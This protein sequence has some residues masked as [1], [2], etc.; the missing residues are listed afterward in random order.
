MSARPEPRGKVRRGRWLVTRLGAGLDVCRAQDGPDSQGIAFQT[1]FA[2]S[3][4][5]SR[6]T[7]QGRKTA[8]KRLEPVFWCWLR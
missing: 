6:T 7:E 1:L 2:L 4:C 3:D 5:T 8:P